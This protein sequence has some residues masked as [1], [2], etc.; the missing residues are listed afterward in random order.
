MRDL[1]G[2]GETNILIGRK[3]NNDLKSFFSQVENLYLKRNNNKNCIN[4]E[5]RFEILTASCWKEK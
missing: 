5:A 3:K 1:R 2:M 4:F